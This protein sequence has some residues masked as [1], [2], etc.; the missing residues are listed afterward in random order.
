MQK[1]LSYF[2]TQKSYFPCFNYNQNNFIH[3]YLW[4]TDLFK[5]FLW[6][7]WT[8]AWQS[9]GDWSRGRKWSGLDVTVVIFCNL[10][11]IP[12]NLENVT[13]WLML[14]NYRSLMHRMI[15]CNG[16]ECEKLENVL[17]QCRWQQVKLCL[18]DIFISN[19]NIK[20]NFWH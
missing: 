3:T 7:F 8:L 19:F 14:L 5:Y 11:K 2:S 9:I 15:L 18:P 1:L 6:W 4:Q 13:R 17:L 10:I 12:F 20:I 16:G